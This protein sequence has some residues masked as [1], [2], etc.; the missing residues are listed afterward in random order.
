MQQY[1]RR[2]DRAIFLGVVQLGRTK[3]GKKMYKKRISLYMA[4]LIV[5]SF[6]SVVLGED[7]NITQYKAEIKMLQ[8]AIASRDAKI[9]KLQ[10]EINDKNL[11]K[12]LVVDTVLANK[13]KASSIPNAPDK[14]DEILGIGP[15]A[16]NKYPELLLNGRLQELLTTTSTK[17]FQVIQ[18]YKNGNKFLWKSHRVLIIF[19]PDVH[20]PLVFT[21]A[22]VLFNVI[23]N[24]EAH[25]IMKNVSLKSVA[26]YEVS[27][28]CFDRF[29]KPVT[30][31]FGK[32]NIVSGISQTTIETGESER[33]SWTL[34]G[35]ETTAKIIITLDKVKFSDGSEWKPAIGN[36]VT[37][38]GTSKK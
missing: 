33:S 26:A 31:M 29:K 35:H 22:G 16:N 38:I 12:Y 15:V 18:R 20:A 37:A 23:G 21:H 17:S 13:L 27:I 30:G 32:I 25:I 14:G 28:A 4:I 1:G 2:G 11:A 7:A 24:P 8:A 5:F 10:K 3:K 19:S 9:E 6:S 34:H 36:P